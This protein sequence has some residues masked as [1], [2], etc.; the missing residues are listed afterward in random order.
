MAP[1]PRI[2]SVVHTA[3]A[4]LDR[5]RR[6]ITLGVLAGIAALSLGA[7][8]MAVM[9]AVF[10][11]GVIAESGALALVGMT[12]TALCGIGTLAAPLVA[13]SLTVFSPSAFEVSDARAV[14]ATWNRSRPTWARALVEPQIHLLVDEAARDTEDVLVARDEVQREVRQVA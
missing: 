13:A 7:S 3:R 5:R 12:A 6:S 4:V 10:M 14:V 11:L 8:G 2:P 1:L 9:G